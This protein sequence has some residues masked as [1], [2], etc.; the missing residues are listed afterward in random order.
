MFTSFIMSFSAALVVFKVPSHLE[1]LIADFNL[2]Y[3][4]AGLFMGL[5]GASVVITAI[6]A[7]ILISR[8]GT[9][10]M[11]IVAIAFMISGSIVQALSQNVYLLFFGR[12]VEGIGVSFAIVT[13]ITIISLA[14]PAAK[15]G[16]ALGLYMA[17]Y[18]A[19]SVI[20][21]NLSS[22]I[23][24]SYGWRIIWWLSSAFAVITL[25]FLLTSGDKR[26]VRRP[27]F[28]MKRSLSN[29][30]LWLLPMANMGVG[31]P[32][33][34]ILNWGPT[35]LSV[36]RG[37]LI[38]VG[39]FL[40]SLTMFMAIPISPIGGWLSDRVRPRKIVYALP[41]LALAVLY[42]LVPYVPLSLFLVFMLVIGFFN[43]LVPPAAM[44]EVAEIAGPEA[45]SVGLAISMTMTNMGILVS[46][47]LFGLIY[48]ATR[49]WNL[50]FLSL[51]IYDAMGLLSALPRKG[52]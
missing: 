3:T 48:D 27:G 40:V 47:P 1:V 24:L 46:S 26:V 19:G 35:Y 13:A 8:Y 51:V 28:S 5:V 41:L 23:P 21:M 39:S 17:C 45:T 43:N 52:K 34:C 11:G 29:P 4:L 44:A 22:L 9:K 30:F 37:V 6:P 14:V 36:A 18:P 16:L 7:G 33:N 12:I 50:S 15:R 2:S 38:P 25:V 10:R 32:G 42:P 31:S 20:S 49:S